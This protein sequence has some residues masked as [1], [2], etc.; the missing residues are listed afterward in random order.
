MIHIYVETSQLS[1]HYHIE[2]YFCFSINSKTNHYHI[3]M[4]RLPII[5]FLLLKCVF[6]S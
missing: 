3:R 4:I 6:Y 2:D 1:N 5:V